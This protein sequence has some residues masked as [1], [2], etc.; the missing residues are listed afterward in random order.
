MYDD[1]K[2]KC[3]K[4]IAY[5]KKEKKK[6]EKKINGKNYEELSKAFNSINWCLGHVSNGL[7]EWENGKITSS[8]DECEELYDKMLYG[9]LKF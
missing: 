6:I 8:F 9:E 3:N 2:E 1:F 4:L 7:N 5:L